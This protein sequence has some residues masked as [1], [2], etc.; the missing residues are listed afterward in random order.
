MCWYFKF[1]K[2]IE[3]R[4]SFFVLVV[5]LWK[6]LLVFVRVS[7]IMWFLSKLILLFLLNINI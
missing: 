7:F 3:S 4:K 1:N 2:E 6:V 5:K